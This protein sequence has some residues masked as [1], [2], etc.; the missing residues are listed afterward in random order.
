MENELVVEG[1]HCIRP[2]GWW[3]K[4][5]QPGKWVVEVKFENG[6]YW[7][8]YPVGNG[9]G[10]EFCRDA[11]NAMGFSGVSLADL[12]TESALNKE[13]PVW[14]TVA[15][16]TYTDKSGNQKVKAVVAFVNSSESPTEYPEDM[17]KK[18]YEIQIN[19]EIPF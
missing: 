3:V 16:E 6:L 9:R 19:D 15:H 10:P 13:A 14:C 11:L 4:E 5:Y 2:V 18:M 12:T 8:G 7:K 1:Q 17:I